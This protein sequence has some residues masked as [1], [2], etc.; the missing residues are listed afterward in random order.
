M[1]Q[2]PREAF[3]AGLSQF[4]QRNHRRIPY[5]QDFRIL[6][7][8][9]TKGGTAKV[10]V[11]KGVKFEHKYYWSNTFRDPEVVNTWV[12][13]RYEPFNAGLV[14]AYVR[15]QWVEC[16]SEYYAH[17]RGRSEKEI[18]HASEEL[19][20][21]QKNHARNYKIRAKQLG[22]FL[23]ST[24]AQEVL[25]EQRLRDG[26]QQ[27]VFQVIEGG[28]PNLMPYS[29]THEIS[30]LQTQTNP[31]QSNPSQQPEPNTQQSESPQTT[32]SAKRQ[33]FKSY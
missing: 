21:R 31:T 12:E 7:L 27:E 14:Y 9:G 1:G 32:K 15:G 18:Q 11:G 25:L 17:F 22:Q 30:N 6:T 5:N 24:E 23:A 19:R 13:V 33:L 4:G 8:P 29:P 3:A 2:S 10:Q 20:R 26:Q 28:M 16:I